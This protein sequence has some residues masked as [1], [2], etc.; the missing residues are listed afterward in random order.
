M[1]GVLG[2]VSAGAA[3]SILDFTN[4]RQIR[5]QHVS[6]AEKTRE[7]TACVTREHSFSAKIEGTSGPK[8]L[9]E[10]VRLQSEK[11]QEWIREIR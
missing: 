1:R 5:A 4:P 6:V 9:D 8:N 3:R 7:H 10:R 11:R 2:R